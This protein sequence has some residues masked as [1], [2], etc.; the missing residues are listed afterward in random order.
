MSFAPS[1][2]AVTSPASQIHA[3][4]ENLSGGFAALPMEATG[5]ETPSVFVDTTRSPTSSIV[6]VTRWTSPR[7]SAMGRR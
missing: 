2:R 3:R 6:P 7:V 5:C 1:V 4:G